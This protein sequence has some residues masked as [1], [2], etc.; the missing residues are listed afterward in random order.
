MTFREE[1]RTEPH[2]E[3]GLT[4]EPLP[5]L[6]EGAPR[7]RSFFQG[8]KISWGLFLTLGIVAILIGLW[9]GL[10]ERKLSPHWGG[11]PS[12][13]FL[14]LKQ[15]LARLAQEVDLLKKEI[16]ALKET[17]KGLTETVRGLKEP[18]VGTPSASVKVHPKPA[19]SPPPSKPLVYRVRKG[20]TWTS[21]ARKFQT[22]PKELRNWNSS[23]KDETLIPGRLLVVRPANP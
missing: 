21:V 12:S 13:E 18:A 8:K 5:P 17:G 7:S 16:Q 9:W 22:T 11:G 23:G 15:E 6:R 4:E 3:I 14:T 10:G 20:D 2:V 1:E 19:K